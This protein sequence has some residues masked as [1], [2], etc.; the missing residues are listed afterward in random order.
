MIC[1]L[2]NPGLCERISFLV[3]SFFPGELIALHSWGVSWLFQGY[4]LPIC[5]RSV[6]LSLLWLFLRV[7]CPVFKTEHA[8]KALCNTMLYIIITL[9]TVIM[10]SRGRGTRLYFT[11][12]PYSGGGGNKASSRNLY[13]QITKWKLANEIG[14]YQT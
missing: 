3:S 12:Q 10:H 14:I 13:N 2:R 7:C 4:G 6:P 8:T 9:A 1:D 5:S 11:S